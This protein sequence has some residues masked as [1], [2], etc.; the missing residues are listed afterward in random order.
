[1]DIFK[2]KHVFFIL[3]LQFSV[4]VSGL[5]AE[6]FPDG[7]TKTLVFDRFN[8]SYQDF[9]PKLDPIKQGPLSIQL[10]SPK[11]VLSLKSHTLALRRIGD[12][13]HAFQVLATFEGSGNLFADIDLMGLT[14][15]LSDTFFI[16]LQKR[17]ISGKIKVEKSTEGYHVTVIS[18]PKH[19]QV[20]VRTGLASKLVTWCE[21]FSVL[22]SSLLDCGNLKRSLTHLKIPLP[23]NKSYFVAYADLSPEE[24]KHL[25]QYFGGP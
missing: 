17:A 13:L 5:A 14:S 8:Q 22:P 9:A 19:T 20:H 4:Q 24:Q 21:R 11:Q 16:P 23:Q 15:Q 12:D 6:T 2:K 25:A 10:S 7:I 3:I 1:M 18:L